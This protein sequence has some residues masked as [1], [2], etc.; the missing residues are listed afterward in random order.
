MF[1]RSDSFF[2]DIFSKVH[3]TLSYINR[4]TF[5][6]LAQWIAYHILRHIRSGYLKVSDRA[7]EYPHT[8]KVLDMV[9]GRGEVRKHGSSVYLKRISSE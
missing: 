3:R 1:V 2:H 4:H 6:S 9:K 5:I 8:K 7:H